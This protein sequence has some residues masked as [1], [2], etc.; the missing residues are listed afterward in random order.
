MNYIRICL[1]TVFLLPAIVAADGVDVSVTQDVLH[2][3]PA[4][5]VFVDYH[6]RGWGGSVGGWDYQGA[7]YAGVL[8]YEWEYHGFRFG[9]G[10]AYLTR[11]SDVNGSRT[12]FS[13]TA[14]RH[15][16][17]NMG[18]VYRHFSCGASVFGIRC[19][20][21]GGFNFLGAFAHF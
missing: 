15:F 17:K 4:K 21:N 7:T 11:T 9:F 1:F 16:H 8:D 6:Y 18:I 5:A 2:A 19:N 12:L 10:G 20:P 14:K 3:S 13:L